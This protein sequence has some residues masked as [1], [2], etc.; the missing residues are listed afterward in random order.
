MLQQ[1]QRQLRSRI[2]YRIILPYLLL[3]AFLIASL[4]TVTFWLYA[5]N[6]QEQLN[7]SLRT[8]A[9]NTGLGLETLEARLLDNLRPVVTGQAN[10][11]EGISSTADAFNNRDVDQIQK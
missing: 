7:Q 11:T 6:L 3:A 8:S 10:P 9:T 5:N 2:R 1:F 4:T